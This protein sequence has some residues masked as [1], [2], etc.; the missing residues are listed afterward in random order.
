MAML[1][2]NASLSFITTQSSALAG[3]RSQLLAVISSIINCV[4]QV[5]IDMDVW[6]FWSLCAN[7]TVNRLTLGLAPLPER[8]MYGGGEVTITGREL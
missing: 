7:Q 5:A 4:F 3:N 2:I 8:Y 6:A 1:I